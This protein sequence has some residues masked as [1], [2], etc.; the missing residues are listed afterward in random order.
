MPTTGKDKIDQQ[1]KEEL[2]G[3]ARIS[4]D[5]RRAV[6]AALPAPPEQFLTLNVPG[7][8]LNFKVRGVINVRQWFSPSQPCP[9]TIPTGGTTRAMPK[10]SYLLSAFSSMRPSFVTTCPPSAVS[11]LVR[12]VDPLPRAT[13]RR[14]ASSVHLVCVSLGGCVPCLMIRA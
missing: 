6:V 7:K 5:I 2:D 3:I 4:L 9:R 14:S 11:N 10:L 8:V 1:R 12:L 13:A